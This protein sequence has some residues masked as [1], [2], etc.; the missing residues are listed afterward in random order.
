MTASL[1][2]WATLSFSVV[3]FAVLLRRFR[4]VALAHDV[5]TVTRRA[6]RTMG[7][8]TLNDD[9]KE[10]RIRHMAG[11]VA[12]LGL[13]I[14]LRSA[15]CLAAAV[16]VVALGAGAGLY[17]IGA[18]TRVAVGAPF[19]LTATAAAIAV[20]WTLASLAAGRERRT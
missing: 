6:L 2:I 18:A 1:A 3:L 10:R 16:A 7:A 20:W 4:I 15:L 11:R 9:E 13:S 12:R 17:T 8:T 5:T 19:I 14:S